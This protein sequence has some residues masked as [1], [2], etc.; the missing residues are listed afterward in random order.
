MAKRK[1][2]WQQ[3][4]G[5][6]ESTRARSK[7]QEVKISDLINGRPSINSGA[8]F[9]Q[10]DVIA[11]WTEP[12]CKTTSKKSYSLK[13]DE[14]NKVVKKTPTTKIPLEIIEFE[15]HDLQLAIIDLDDLMMLV[16]KIE[17]GAIEG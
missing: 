10:N 17:N 1:P 9:G 13:V 16:E 14:W 12:E 6:P 15:E 8:T 7:R 2:K 5:T 4:S 11:D 3:E